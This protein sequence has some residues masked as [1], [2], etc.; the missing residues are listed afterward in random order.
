M[1]DP[2]I[3]LT[4][5]GK[6]Y[7]IFSSR[8]DNLVDALGLNKVLPRRES[9]HRE[10]W[11][12]RGIDLTVERGARIG[13]I[14]RNGAGKST[15]LKLITGALALTEGTLEVNGTIQALIDAG[16]GFH[17]EF[18]GYENIN[19]SLT[20]QGFSREELAAAQ[21]DIE[22]FTE[23]GGFLEQ[24]LKTYS[25][26]MQARLAFA[27]ATAIK[28]EVLVVD[29]V[30]GAGD[31]YFITKSVER[32]NRI[33]SSGASMLIVSHSLAQIT[34]LC[35]EAIWLERGRI[36]ARGRSIDVV[37][38]YERY[39]REL[40]EARLRDRNLKRSKGTYTSLELDQP[41]G[42]L[43]I[44]LEVV[45]GSGT[46]CEVAKMK[47]IRDAEPVETVD[48]GAP[49]DGNPEH[50][51]FVDLAGS[52]WS[53]P[54]ETNGVYTRTLTPESDNPPAGSIVFNM[55]HFEESSTYEV[56]VDYRC[57][58]DAVVAVEAIRGAESM[59][60]GEVSANGGAWQ[61]TRFPIRGFGAADEPT[62]GGSGHVGR[63]ARLSYWPGENSLRIATV[64]LTNAA[65]QEC[66]VFNNGERLTLTVAFEAQ[67]A[68]SYQVLPVAVIYRLDGVN[69]STQLGEWVTAYFEPGTTHRA[70]VTLDD[71]NLGNGNYLVSIA[72]YKSFDPDLHESPVV[73]D[74]VDRSIEFQVV[75]TSTAITSVFQHPSV[76]RLH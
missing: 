70:S 25:L 53:A 2:A 6:M 66:T 56:E 65:G 29:E 45:S 9:R 61:T 41:T 59:S 26:G 74:W 17:P 15:L 20:Y 16:A 67:R 48:V 40:E 3:R 47:I 69:I 19:A 13:V 68:D 44:R 62:S 75:G 30:L 23:L 63:D 27:T 34:Q 12:L 36:V 38:Q 58:G 4:D 10:F 33:T 71:L 24:P 39:V 11:A 31:A 5:V 21:K 51:A 50:P 73:Y 35:D 60:L 22:E 28:P 64:S 76:W 32:M 54:R 49:Q 43:Q 55:F 7:K 52:N 57:K 46:S 14:G 8:R 72:L 42:T 37:K 18:T 1:S